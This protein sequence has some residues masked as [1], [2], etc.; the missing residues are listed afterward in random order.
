MGKTQMWLVPIKDM[1]VMRPRGCGPQ[2]P[3]KVVGR[4]WLTNIKALKL[5]SLGEGTFGSS[6]GFQ[7]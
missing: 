7:A 3:G 6:F 5:D 1:G 2:D 4:E